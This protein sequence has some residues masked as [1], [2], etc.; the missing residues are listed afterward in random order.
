MAEA[1]WYVDPMGSPNTLRYWNGTAWTN[2]TMPNPQQESNSASQV[3][4]TQSGQEQTQPQQ[5]QAQPQVQQSQESQPQSQPQAQAEGYAQ[6][7]QQPQQ[8]QTGGQQSQ[9]YAQQPVNA[10]VNNYSQQPA[11]AG[12]TPSPMQPGQ[13]YPMSETDR[14]LRLIAFIWN[15][16]CTVTC[17]VLILPLAWMVP[18]TVHSYNIYRGRKPNTVAF[19]VC[20]LLFVG[21]VSGILLLC[22]KKEA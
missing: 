21:V 4:T 9:P 22:S 12:Y 8:P 5:P 6:Q 3:N 17:A 13:I 1:G 7:Y 10:N 19:G 14:T 2:E 20:T 18:M 11:G 15:I 16:V